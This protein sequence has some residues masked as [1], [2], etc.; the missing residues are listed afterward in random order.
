MKPAIEP[1][2]NLTLLYKDTTVMHG[3]GKCIVCAVGTNTFRY[4][5]WGA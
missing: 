5:K 2:E 3:F 4:K 1:S